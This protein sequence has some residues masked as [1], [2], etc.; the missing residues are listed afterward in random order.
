MGG[1]AGSTCGR[2]LGAGRRRRGRLTDGVL[3]WHRNRRVGL[4]GDEG[5]QPSQRSRSGE[6]PVPPSTT[7]SR[8]RHSRT[9]LGCVA[10]A[11]REDDVG[12]ER[13]GRAERDERL[14]QQPAWV[15]PAPVRTHTAAISIPHSAGCRQ[16][17]GLIW[18]HTAA[19]SIPHGAGCLAVCKRAAHWAHQLVPSGDQESRVCTV[20]TLAGRA[21]SFYRSTSNSAR[22]VCSRVGRGGDGRPW[23]DWAARHRRP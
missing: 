23:R 3:G 17:I 16:L 13:P 22:G 8:P 15:H 2:S 11:C 6:S 12:R 19:V 21:S 20:P 1:A 10:R 9:G 18:G 5:G 4:M 14:A 7:L